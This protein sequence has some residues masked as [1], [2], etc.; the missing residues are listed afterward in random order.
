MDSTGLA[1]IILGYQKMSDFFVTEDTLEPIH[2][3][4]QD[5][6]DEIKS[7]KKQTEKEKDDLTEK[8]AEQVQLKATRERE[9]KKISR[10]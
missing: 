10:Q 9:K 6:L 7:T 4:I 5:T 2:R 3:L 1:E 8:Q